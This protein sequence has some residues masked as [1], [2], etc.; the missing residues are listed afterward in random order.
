MIENTY[1]SVVDWIC[2]FAYPSLIDKCKQGKVKVTLTGC[3]N[4]DTQ[5]KWEEIFAGKRD[6]DQDAA[7]TSILGTPST[8]LWV[9]SVK[10][11]S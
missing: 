7:I 11:E 4:T 5:T 10:L 6:H 8:E 1:T 2:T 3:V 9:P